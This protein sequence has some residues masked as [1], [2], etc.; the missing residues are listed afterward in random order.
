MA[1]QNG[2]LKTIAVVYLQK[3]FSHKLL[4]ILENNGYRQFRDN[5]E[6]FIN[7]EQHVI[8]TGGGCEELLCKRDGSKLNLLLIDTGGSSLAEADDWTIGFSDAESGKYLEDGEGDQLIL[9]Y[10]R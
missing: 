6:K 2:K 4:R 5:L 9:E 3:L 10:Q 1:L 7:T 8:D